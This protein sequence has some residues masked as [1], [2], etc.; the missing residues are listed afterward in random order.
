MLEEKT[1]V[2]EDCPFCGSSNIG[3]EETLF[4]DSGAF[5]CVCRDCGA[6]GPVSLTTED[7]AV[8]LWNTRGG[9]K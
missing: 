9:K 3:L 5:W 2:L 7:F 6:E 4:D 8:E 1:I